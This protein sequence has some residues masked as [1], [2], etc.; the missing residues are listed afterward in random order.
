MIRLISNFGENSHF[1]MIVYRYRH[2]D[3]FLFF[4]KK[5]YGKILE[6]IINFYDGR[7]SFIM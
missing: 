7:P 6:N 3:K 2:L 1:T 4:K 5:L